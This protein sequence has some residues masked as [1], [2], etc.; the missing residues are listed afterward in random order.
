MMGCFIRS[1]EISGCATGRVV[2]VRADK[3]LFHNK[4]SDKA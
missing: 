2:K 4:T 3:G 1:V